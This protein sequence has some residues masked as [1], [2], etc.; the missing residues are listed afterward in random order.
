MATHERAPSDTSS[1]RGSVGDVKLTALPSPM[2]P[3][4]VLASPTP[5]ST[6][7]S[8]S[9]LSSS[10]EISVGQTMRDV[11][12]E[13][14]GANPSHVYLSS[15]TVAES[16]SSSH[17]VAPSP[18]LTSLFVESDAEDDNPSISPYRRHS[19]QF[20]DPIGDAAVRSKPALGQ[21]TPRGLVPPVFLRRS[22][23]GSITLTA[24]IMPQYRKTRL[25]KATQKPLSQ[26]RHI[27]NM[28]ANAL[29]DMPSA[30]SDLT[31]RA[32]LRQLESAAGSPRLQIPANDTLL[33]YL[34]DAPSPTNSAQASASLAKALVVLDE[35]MRSSR[36]KHLDWGDQSDDG[37]GTYSVHSSESGQTSLRSGEVSPFTGLLFENTSEKDSVSQRR[38]SQ[39]GRKRRPIESSIGSPQFSLQQSAA[40]RL[41]GRESGRLQPK[42]PVPTHL[43]LES[44]RPAFDSPMLASIQIPELQLPDSPQFMP[45][46]AASSGLNPK[47]NT[48]PVSRTSSRSLSR[49]ASRESLASNSSQASYRSTSS[50]VSGLEGARKPSTLLSENITE[51][52]QQALEI[53]KEVQPEDVLADD[54]A[55]KRQLLLID[56]P[57]LPRGWREFDPRL[58][59]HDGTIESPKLDDGFQLSA[60]YP[61]TMEPDAADDVPEL[62]PAAKA[63]RLR[64]LAALEQVWAKQMETEG[65]ATWRLRDETYLD[66]LEAERLRLVRAEQILARHLNRQRGVATSTSGAE[67]PRTPSGSRSVVIP[68]PSAKS[69]TVPSSPRASTPQSPSDSSGRLTKRDSQG[70]TA[71]RASG[72]FA[73]WR[74]QMEKAAQERSRAEGFLL[75]GT[76]G[77]SLWLP[78]ERESY[79]GASLWRAI[80]LKHGIGASHGQTPATSTNGQQP[81]SA[82]SEE[83][84]QPQIVDPSQSSQQTSGANPPSVAPEQTGAQPDA[85]GTAAS[86]APAR[87][88]PVLSALSQS[89]LHPS[90]AMQQKPQPEPTIQPAS[91]SV[92]DVIT[93]PPGTAPMTNW[94]AVFLQP[95]LF[96]LD[97]PSS[98]AAE[99]RLRFL[100]HRL[101]WRARTGTGVPPSALAYFMSGADLERIA[102]KPK[103]RED[104][105]KLFNKLAEDDSG[106]APAT[107]QQI[108]QPRSLA[109]LLHKA[110]FGSEATPT[111][112]TTSLLTSAAATGMVISPR[113]QSNELLERG[114]LP[115]R[116]RDDISAAD[117][118]AVDAHFIKSMRVLTR[119]WRRLESYIATEHAMLARSAQTFLRRYRESFGGVDTAREILFPHFLRVKSR[120]MEWAERERAYA[121]SMAIGRVSSKF[122]LGPSAFMRDALSPD[123]ELPLYS[124]QA[125][126]RRRMNLFDDR[127]VY[128]SLRFW[129]LV[130]RVYVASNWLDQVAAQSA[131]NSEFDPLFAPLPA[132]ANS[133]FE[134]FQE[135]PRLV[136]QEPNSM[137]SAGPQTASVPDPLYRTQ[138]TWG[139]PQRTV[140]ARRL[141]E[142]PLR[143]VSSPKDENA[144]FSSL[145]SPGGPP[146]PSTSESDHPSSPAAENGVPESIALAAGTTAGL[147]TWPQYLAIMLRII[148]VLQPSMPAHTALELCRRDWLA[149][150]GS[151]QFDLADALATAAGAYGTH[152]YTVA[153]FNGVSPSSNFG[154]SPGLNDIAEPQ[155]YPAAGSP[156]SRPPRRQAF[157]PPPTPQRSLPTFHFTSSRSLAHSGVTRSPGE[158][159]SALVSSLFASPVSNRILSTEHSLLSVSQH[160]DPDVTYDG[161]VSPY[162]S[163]LLLPILVYSLSG[164]L[165]PIGIVRHLPG[166]RLPR[167]GSLLAE[168]ARTGNVGHT[169]R[170]DNSVELDDDDDDSSASSDDD[171]DDDLDS[172]R[173]PGRPEAKQHEDGSY[174]VRYDDGIVVVGSVPRKQVLKRMHQNRLVG[175][176]TAPLSPSK[177]SPSVGGALSDN[178]R[179]AE[180]TSPS[181]VELETRAREKLD[182][183]AALAKRAELQTRLDALAQRGSL[184]A[185][186]ASLMSRRRRAGSIA[187]PAAEETLDWSSDLSQPQALNRDSSGRSVGPDASAAIYASFALLGDASTI[188]VPSSRPSARPRPPPA[189]ANHPALVD[190]DLSLAMED[191]FLK[192]AF[193]VI[194]FWVFH[195]SLFS[196]ADLWTQ[197]VES[198]EYID[199]LHFLYCTITHIPTPGSRTQSSSDRA[200]MRAFTAGHELKPL[201]PQY[202]AVLNAESALFA[203]CYPFL[204]ERNFP[205][206][207]NALP[208]SMPTSS[209]DITKG[210]PDATEAARVSVASTTGSLDGPSTTQTEN[211]PSRQVPRGHLSA[212]KAQGRI[213]SSRPSASEQ[214]LGA[215]ADAQ[216][217]V[218]GNLIPAPDAYVAKDGPKRSGLT[219]RSTPAMQSSRPTQDAQQPAGSNDT[220][221][222]V[223]KI[224]RR[225]ERERLEEAE[226][227]LAT[228]RALLSFPTLAELADIR[229]RKA[230]RAALAMLGHLKDGHSLDRRSG[231]TRIRH[232]KVYHVAAS[233]EGGSGGGAD[234]PGSEPSTAPTSPLASER[235]TTFSFEPGHT[236]HRR[237]KASLFPQSPRG[238]VD[239]A[240]HSNEPLARPSTPVAAPDIHEIRRLESIKPELSRRLRMRR[241]SQAPALAEKRRRR[242]LKDAN[243]EASILRGEPRDDGTTDLDADDQDL[244]DDEDFAASLGVRIIGGGRSGAS[245]DD[246]QDAKARET[247][248][249]ERAERK[250]AKEERR[251]KAGVIEIPMPEEQ[252]VLEIKD[253]PGDREARFRYLEQYRVRKYLIARFGEPEELDPQPPADHIEIYRA[254]RREQAMAEARQMALDMERK[255]A[256]ADLAE[257]L[258]ARLSAQS[259]SPIQVLPIEG[260]RTDLPNQLSL[261]LRSPH[262]DDHRANVPLS[263]DLPPLYPL[264]VE[265]RPLSRDEIDRIVQLNGIAL[266]AL[267]S[268]LDDMFEFKVVFPRAA[269]LVTAIV[270][271]FTDGLTREDLSRVTARW[272]P[273]VA[274][275]VLQYY[276]LIRSRSQLEAM[277]VAPPPVATEEELGDELLKDLVIPSVDPE[278]KY[279][280]SQPAKP[281]ED[282]V[283]AYLVIVDRNG[284]EQI[285]PFRIDPV[286][287]PKPM[288]SKAKD[289]KAQPKSTVSPSKDETPTTARS[290]RLIHDSDSS[291]GPGSVSSRQHPARQRRSR[292]SHDSPERHHSPGSSRRGG[293][294]A[295]ASDETT[296]SQSTRD[297]K[298]QSTRKRK[299][300][301]RRTSTRFRFEDVVTAEGEGG[302][303]G[304]T[305]LDLHPE[306]Y[307]RFPQTRRLSS[308]ASVE[309]SHQDET[310]SPVDRHAHVHPH[311][312]NMSPTRESDGDL[313]D[314]SEFDRSSSEDSGA[315][316]ASENGRGDT[317][318]SSGDDSD[319]EHFRR[320]HRRMSLGAADDPIDYQQELNRILART[321]MKFEKGLERN[322]KLRSQRS[323]R[324][325]SRKA[326]KEEARLMKQ[327]LAQVQG[328]LADAEYIKVLGG[329][330]EVILPMSGQDGD[331]QGSD[332]FRTPA[333]GR[334]FSLDNLA[335]AA[336]FRRA[337]LPSGGPQLGVPILASPMDLSTHPELGS[338]VFNFGTS[339]RGQ[340]RRHVFQRSGKEDEVSSPL[341][342][343]PDHPPSEDVK[344]PHFHLRDDGS[345]LSLLS[346]QPSMDDR[347]AKTRDRR[348]GVSQSGFAA[349]G[350]PMHQGIHARAASGTPLSDFGSMKLTLVSTASTY[351]SEARPWSGRGSFEGWGSSPHP[352]SNLTGFEN[353]LGETL[354][355]SIAVGATAFAPSSDDMD[356]SDPDGQTLRGRFQ[357]HVLKFL[358]PARVRER[359]VESAL[360]RG[361]ISPRHVASA[362]ALD[363]AIQAGIFAIPYSDSRAST[364]SGSQTLQETQQG[365]LRGLGPYAAFWARYDPSSSPRPPSSQV[366]GTQPA[367]PSSS[368]PQSTPQLTL[369]LSFEAALEVLSQSGASRPASAQH[370][371]GRSSIHR[372]VNAPGEPRKPSIDDSS[373]SMSFPHMF[374]LRN[375]PVTEL[376]REGWERF[377]SNAASQSHSTPRSSL[378]STSNSSSASAQGA[379]E[380]PMSPAVLAQR[381]GN[382]KRASETPLSTLPSAQD[383]K[384]NMHEWIRGW[385]W[386]RQ[387]APRARPGPLFSSAGFLA[388]ISNMGL[389]GWTTLPTGTFTQDET[390][391]PVLTPGDPH[392]YFGLPDTHDRASVKALTPRHVKQ[393]QSVDFTQIVSATRTSTTATT[394]TLSASTTT[395]SGLHLNSSGPNSSTSA[396]GA[397]SP[398]QIIQPVGQPNQLSQH[399]RAL[400]S[401]L[402]ESA[403]YDKGVDETADL[404]SPS[405]DLSS[406]QQ[407][408]RHIRSVSVLSGR[409]DVSRHHARLAGQ[410]SPRYAHVLS[411]VQTDLSPQPNNGDLNTT[412][413]IAQLETHRYSQPDVSS[414]VKSSSLQ[415]ISDQPQAPSVESSQIE[416]PTLDSHAAVLTATLN[417]GTSVASTVDQPV[418]SR[419]VHDPIL[420]STMSNL[421]SPA[422]GSVEDHRPTLTG[423]RRISTVSSLRSSNRSSLLDYARSPHASVISEAGEASLSSLTTGN[424]T[425]QITGTTAST[426]SIQNSDF[427]QSYELQNALL[428][429]TEEGQSARDLPASSS[430]E[431]HV[432]GNVSEIAREIQTL[433]P[434]SRTPPPQASAQTAQGA[435]QEP[436]HV[437]SLALSLRQN[438]SP[439]LHN[440]ADLVATYTPSDTSASQ[441]APHDISPTTD[442][443]SVEGAFALAIAAAARE[444]KEYVVDTGSLDWQGNEAEAHILAKFATLA[445][446]W[447]NACVNPNE[448]E[449]LYFIYR[450][451]ELMKTRSNTTGL[452]SRRAHPGHTSLEEYAAACKDQTESRRIYSQSGALSTPLHML[453]S[454]VRGISPLSKFKEPPTSQSEWDSPITSSS[455]LLHFLHSEISRGYEHLLRA[456]ERG[457]VVADATGKDVNML[458]NV[459]RRT[460]SYDS[461]RADKPA[462][463][464]EFENYSVLAQQ[465]EQEHW[466]WVSELVGS[467][468]TVEKL[469]S[470]TVLETSTQSPA[471]SYS[472]LD[473]QDAARAPL[474]DAPLLNLVPHP[475]PLDIASV[476]H[477]PP[478]TRP[479]LT[480]LGR[481]RQPKVRSDPHVKA[482][483]AS[484]H[485]PS[486]PSEDS[487]HMQPPSSTDDQQ[488]SAEADGPRHPTLR[489]IASRLAA[490][491]E[492]VNK[493][494]AKLY[495][496]E[497]DR[498]IK[499]QL[500]SCIR[501]R[502]EQQAV[503]AIRAAKES[504][505][506]QQQALREG[507]AA[508]DRIRRETDELLAGMLNQHGRTLPTASTVPALHLPADAVPT[509]LPAQAREG[510]SLAASL[511]P[512]ESIDRYASQVRAIQDLEAFQQKLIGRAEQ[513]LSE[514]PSLSQ[515]DSMQADDENQRRELDAWEY[516]IS[517]SD[518][519][520]NELLYRLNKSHDFTHRL[521]A[522]LFLRAVEERA[523]RMLFTTHRFNHAVATLA[524]NARQM[525]IHDIEPRKPYV[526]IEDSERQAPGRSRS[527]RGIEPGSEVTEPTPVAAAAAAVAAAGGDPVAFSSGWLTQAG[528]FAFEQR[529]RQGWLQDLLE[530]EEKHKAKDLTQSHPEHSEVKLPDKPG[531]SPMPTHPNAS[532]SHQISTRVGNQSKTER[533][534]F[535]QAMAMRRSAILQSLTKQTHVLPTTQSVAMPTGRPTSSA[536]PPKAQTH[537]HVVQGASN[538][539]GGITGR[540]G[541][542]YSA[543]TH[544]TGVPQSSSSPVPLVLPN[545]IAMPMN[546]M[547]TSSS[548]ERVKNSSNIIFISPRPLDSRFSTSTSRPATNTETK[549][550]Y[551]LPHVGQTQ[552]KSRQ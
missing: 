466:A 190:S 140:V 534:S 483:A 79:R 349:P 26:R 467:I 335:V 512:F 224:R 520:V 115:I 60:E 490:K 456:R 526:Y 110:F 143:Q 366:A 249:R 89:I 499:S 151:N 253:L 417:R 39:L 237:R 222:I 348:H 548:S 330:E 209:A 14:K 180:S 338:K 133:F 262:A 72:L 314:D 404:S 436:G 532:V 250:K 179:R 305:E 301:G 505:K 136:P 378:T 324:K 56:N 536:R 364:T 10:L 407:R 498:L 81:G 361:Q 54:I 353:Q 542:I 263:S 206:A 399:E 403:A 529:L 74:A 424:T 533:L 504:I 414:A 158:I 477:A 100:I 243:D 174:R 170:V 24:D 231:T 178:G 412:D 303:S 217:S 518:P 434:H 105:F 124:T 297:A 84:E 131:N 419:G 282:V 103:R 373:G 475:A 523:V 339:Q 159:V 116:G 472:S 397:S 187:G 375:T 4:G 50:Q 220:L 494:S 468:E 212:T 121:L 200:Y 130:N 459:E 284:D 358:H 392:A 446:M 175:S 19:Q 355:T 285:I 448:L 251:K 345:I 283:S 221:Y 444:A 470:L 210:N 146:G 99:D 256:A 247:R 447:P 208:K 49:S 423:V 104:V 90:K 141:G 258:S 21:G 458:P 377:V 371:R 203:K 374:A 128:L 287:R 367:D 360:R 43:S 148:R 71:R 73:R 44:P 453:S 248:A 278:A 75:D 46:S 167:S 65:A 230:E 166:G 422:D 48:R 331:T 298:Q 433:I 350:S 363:K 135:T 495:W 113:S 88:G 83:V 341:V 252:R 269:D 527:I 469:N 82:S 273:R 550:E 229:S 12:N 118:A 13:T 225:V 196:L 234:V 162:P 22:S 432:P 450:Q 481:G 132:A 294:P 5:S 310:L 546:K 313:E 218:T 235:S 333:V 228:Q 122:G 240:S 316:E 445:V 507:I 463:S 59:K 474:H 97:R 420:V 521:I 502:R 147:M 160:F 2:I 292:G 312:M 347:G 291:V 393:A 93:H 535:T 62:A 61:M 267:A 327:K 101:I 265:Q 98:P 484:D 42:Q 244:E 257:K 500:R 336:R 471:T 482:G 430:V 186:A 37:E 211:L 270:L 78:G 232:G 329:D 266:A 233:G 184:D 524:A 63:L 66:E 308:I 443:S 376:L 181:L 188:A 139:P 172:G 322:L 388:G 92:P 413:N 356:S 455:G 204:G 478:L 276:M 365:P 246:E 227:E 357:R 238:H 306:D 488:H 391:P 416:S 362:L 182:R 286:T 319:M 489:F 272:P 215:S 254:W 25:D 476:L 473:L 126:F 185:L 464:Y 540:K 544:E 528:L 547:E 300:R 154:A 517:P 219:G 197:S 439:D 120:A 323:R 52:Q 183:A 261:H 551:V 41:S 530:E 7:S 395:T 242:R 111:A 508:A 437:E 11:R 109:T 346:D 359:L 402:D 328:R 20:V 425:G 516:A 47:D 340:S 274:R 400:S 163:S 343:T 381:F 6:L 15:R 259:D 368:T 537:V 514:D 288:R 531:S 405:S 487:R 149:D 123:Q 496:K 76:T 337:S 525:Q 86:Q 152:A 427:F 409:G 45:L 385:K 38:T 80:I 383:S 289:R 462:S 33:E 168:R 189:I 509:V 396:S 543:S 442:D 199:F 9:E 138:P 94:V 58:L 134:K 398:P 268:L 539:G 29:E 440:A 372:P 290:S 503:K 320:L 384:K 87:Q 342:S 431:F 195:Y 501:L 16:R 156:L 401:A 260:L 36:R 108:H 150:S 418:S 379:P 119:S 8:L 77:A 157:F 318:S 295:E 18:S 275:F 91:S 255:Q 354:P 406:K 127:L 493:R 307:V 245:P 545:V 193:P 299:A 519:Q 390:S 68:S 452:S 408:R 304:S 223:E 497:L 549:V 465:I 70:T 213:L 479:S 352:G 454:F 169:D 326:T 165:P 192:R 334:T 106:N 380:H 538:Y 53:I 153:A 522:F 277:N 491:A 264:Y 302:A 510:E 369:S 515:P 85:D 438:T 239:S 457:A 241:A 112:A 155:R 428:T 194:P 321:R 296:P 191:P 311:L 28:A 293:G 95:R 344:T 382:A 137:H 17:S 102:P 370:R 205:L 40:S 30:P 485:S 173:A 309:E 67:T 145:T 32:P 176:P 394:L 387:E 117:L 279:I 460:A 506:L 171:D 96:S 389:T 317:D 236:A 201:P 411:S 35:K 271:C 486:S 214:S 3:G 31:G 386:P 281:P 541:V 325:K 64:Q 410:L 421:S 202:E 114:A 429:S 511:A 164:L 107:S 315:S 449:R 441:D 142:T 27:E 69:R 1:H 207:S 480:S 513:L 426:K 34:N 226:A 144:S 552:D 177:P 198:T 451:D 435:P 461:L 280:S 51:L 55:T 351:I 216:P 332:H 492:H 23:Q 129:D 161:G 57:Q 415:P 125:L